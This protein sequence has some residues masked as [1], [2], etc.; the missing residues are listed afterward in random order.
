MILAGRGTVLMDKAIGIGWVVCLGSDK[1]GA[2]Y[3]VVDFGKTGDKASLFE[4]TWAMPVDCLAID[5]DVSGEATV[6]NAMQEA[7][8]D[9]SHIDILVYSAGVTN[10]RAAMHDRDRDVWNGTFDVNFKGVA[11][12]MKHVDTHMRAVT[13]G[14]STPRLSLFTSLSRI[15]E[16]DARPRPRPPR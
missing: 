8:V 5:V 2:H 4:E 9:L 11:N 6:R 14:S 3:A 1:A 12:G 16:R 7:I 15:T 13:A 10:P